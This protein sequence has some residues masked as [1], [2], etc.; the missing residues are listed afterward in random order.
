MK[1]IK[2][3]LGV[4]DLG[5]HMMDKVRLCCLY[6]ALFFR[7]R[8]SGHAS[9]AS[10]KQVRI[11][12]D[13]K[14]YDFYIQ[15]LLDFHVLR[16]IFIDWQYVRSVDEA[17]EQ[18]VDLG[19][20]IGATIVYFAH[21]FPRA[22][23]VAVE[24]NG[25]CLPVLKKNAEQFGDRVTVLPWAVTDADMEVTMYPNDEHWSASLIHR[26]GD[27]T[28]YSVPGKTLASICA[29]VGFDEIDFMKCDIEGSE[30]RIFSGFDTRRIRTLVCELHPAVAQK[31][32]EDF[33]AFFPHHKCVKCQAI[34]PH[35]H[36]ELRV[37]E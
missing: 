4:C 17:L 18:V 7:R 20:N 9:F 24:P 2:A 27:K 3:L 19:A 11:G 15:H 34:G 28:G 5:L 16:E 31:T 6:C 22:R 26:R 8:L 1:K 10:H 30:Y 14:G 32:V 35:V 33:F 37:N 36:V 25:A 12:L 13:G 23:I 21:I 29:S